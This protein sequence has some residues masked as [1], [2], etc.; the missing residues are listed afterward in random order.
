MDG[1]VAVWRIPCSLSKD[2]LRKAMKNIRRNESEASEA[3][4]ENAA[5][6]DLELRESDLSNR[7]SMPQ[8]VDVEQ[9]QEN[10]L[11]RRPP[12]PIQKDGADKFAKVYMLDDIASI[13][14]GK[15]KDKDCCKEE[16]LCLFEAR[17]HSGLVGSLSFSPAGEFVASGCDKG[18][19]NIWSITVRGV[20]YLDVALTMYVP[21]CLKILKASN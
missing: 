12:E 10:V 9:N 1:A 5:P 3:L 6:E 7:L 8:P 14:S 4:I 15:D 20:P 18:T 2:Q 19:M 21:Q 11:G 17:G 13:S 16:V